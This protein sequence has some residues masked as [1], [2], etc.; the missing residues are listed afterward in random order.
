MQS[1]LFVPSQLTLLRELEGTFK[2]DLAKDLGVSPATITGWENGA[3]VPSSANVR[4]LSVRFG[5]DPDYFTYLDHAAPA[6]EPFFRSLRSTTVAERTKSGAYADVAERIIR[7]LD[8]RVNFPDF[9]DFGSIDIGTPEESAAMVRAELGI[10]KDPIPNLVDVV[11]AAGIFVVFGPKSST[12]VDA[13][14]RISHPNPIVILNPAKNDY[15]RQRFD[16]AHEVGHIVLHSS[17]QAGSKEIE[18]EANRF[19]AELLAPSEIIC[20][21]LP[22]SVTSGGW[23]QLRILKE[24]WG[25]SMQSLLYRAKHLAIMSD[26]AYRNAMVT[27]SKRGWRRGEPGNRSMLETPTLL[28]SAISLLNEFGYGTEEVAKE[29]GVPLKSLQQVIRH[30]PALG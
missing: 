29:A 3:R 4:R 30:A 22:N 14:S 17:E 8:Q 11:E 9:K 20:D 23:R 25:I 7:T 13:F 21:S 16:L 28:P 15:Y 18:H 10:G 27:V 5:V 19:A 2:T 26:Q 12:S 1:D 24:Q 6:D